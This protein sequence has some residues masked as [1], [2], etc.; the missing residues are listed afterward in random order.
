MVPFVVRGNHLY[1]LCFVLASRQNTDLLEIVLLASPPFQYGL[2]GGQKINVHFHFGEDGDEAVGSGRHNKDYMSIAR[3]RRIKTGSRPRIGEA[4]TRTP[5]FVRV[6]VHTSDGVRKFSVW[7]G[8]P[9][10]SSSGLV[11]RTLFLAETGVTCARFL[12][13]VHV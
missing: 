3:R 9:S 4:E 7:R 12:G 1:T 13:R 11:F 5:H 6:T 8:Q 10:H 2:V